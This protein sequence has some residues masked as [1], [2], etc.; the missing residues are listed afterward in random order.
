M[1]AIRWNA[2]C[3]TGLLAHSFEKLIY[4]FNSV[5][6]IYHAGHAPIRT[7]KP[8]ASASFSLVAPAVLWNRANVSITAGC[9]AARV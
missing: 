9:A 1:S 8:S 4:R 3:G 5:A 7:A 2:T 6:R